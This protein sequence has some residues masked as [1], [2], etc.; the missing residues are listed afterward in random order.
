MLVENSEILAAAEIKARCQHL[1]E[2]LALFDFLKRGE[3]KNKGTQRIMG[4]IMELPKERASTYPAT[5]G[6]WAVVFR[7]DTKGPC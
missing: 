1:G 5:Q 3:A 2:C 6:T 4:G 7:Q